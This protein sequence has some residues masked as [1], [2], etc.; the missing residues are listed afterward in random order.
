ML[1]L[2]T[3]LLCLERAHLFLGRYSVRLITYGKVLW[4][5]SVKTVNFRD[6]FLTISKEEEQFMIES[7]ACRLFR[8]DGS[9]Y[10]TKTNCKENYEEYR[11]KG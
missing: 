10:G 7:T 6:W 3:F 2:P 5:T 11:G 4:F 1:I 8:N 9:I